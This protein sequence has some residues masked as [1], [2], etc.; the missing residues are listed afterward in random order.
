MRFGLPTTWA[1]CAVIVLGCVEQE[2]VGPGDGQPAALQIEPTS[3]DFGGLEPGQAETAEIRITNT[4]GSPAQLAGATVVGVGSFQVSD[5]TLATSLLP[6]VTVA[7]EVRYAPPGYEIGEAV[8]VLETDVPDAPQVDLAGYGI[9]PAI[10]IDPPTHDFDVCEVGCDEEQEVAIRNVGNAPLQLHDVVFEP[11][12]DELLVSFLFET[13]TLQEG[14]EETLV[15]YYRPRDEAPDSAYLTVTC[16]D[17]LRPEA[18]AT[19][20][21]QAQYAPAITDV[22]D[23][24]AEYQADILWVLDNSGNMTGYDAL[25]LG[26]TATILD[27]LEDAEIDFH[28]AVVTTDDAHFHGTEPLMTPTTQ[29]LLSAFQDAADVGDGGSSP[30][31]GLK[32]ALDALTPPLASPG[33]PNDHFLRDEAG[34]QVVFHANEDDQSPNAAGYYVQ[35]LQSLKLFPE[36]V[37]ISGIIQQATPSPQYESAIAA[38]GGTVLSITEDWWTG[39]PDLIAGMASLNDTFPLSASPIPDTVQVSIDGAPVWSGWI[40][41]EELDVVVFEPAAVPSPGSE[42]AITYHPWCNCGF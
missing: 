21:G 29:D 30:E 41:V 24:T 40:L 32:M 1:L 38:T 26:Q 31:Q 6:G 37:V 18:E 2:T 42:I 35:Q 5:E 36:D 12:S 13:T 20:T 15:V 27:L 33:G 3:V 19:F 10:E 28:L 16:N 34:L 22:F 39:L 4:G 9:A 14:E 25:F 8:M 23:Q 7:L 17:P 11:T